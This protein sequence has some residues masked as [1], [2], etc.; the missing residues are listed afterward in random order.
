MFPEDDTTEA[1]TKLAE[2]WSF[3]AATN[4]ASLSS[5]FWSCVTRRNAALLSGFTAGVRGAVREG[6]WCTPGANGRLQSA[7]IVPQTSDFTI[8]LFLGFPNALA[9]VQTLLSNPKMSV[10]VTA[11]GLLKTELAGVSATGTSSLA[12]GRWHHVAVVRRSNKLEVWVDGEKEGESAET[13]ATVY[14]SIS[15]VEAQWAL[16]SA[17]NANANPVVTNNEF[18]GVYQTNKIGAVCNYNTGSDVSI[19]NVYALYDTN[20]QTYMN[21]AI[22]ASKFSGNT[23]KF[24]F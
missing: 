12:D 8:T 9:G 4:P 1:I 10:S 20:I 19:H 24:L 18:Y 5:A 21:G 3:N 6:L 15:G 16:L 13:T 2:Y 7:L 17:S 14:D 23:I 11:D 22:G